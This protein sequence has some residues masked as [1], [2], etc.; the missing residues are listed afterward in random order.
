MGLPGPD[1]PVLEYTDHE[2]TSSVVNGR[3]ASNSLD[4]H[5]FK[6]GLNYRF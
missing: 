6:I 1:Q 2:G 4:M 5:S 3:W